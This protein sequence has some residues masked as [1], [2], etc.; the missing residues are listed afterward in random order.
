[1]GFGVDQVAITGQR[2]TSDADIFDAIDLPNVRSVLSLDSRAVRERIERLPWVATADL[3][4]IYPGQLTIRIAERRPYAVWTR[5]ERDYLVDITGRVLSP[6]KAQP[7][8]RLPRVAGQGAAEEASQLMT[9]L[10]R[11]PGISER[12]AWAERVGGRR[13]TLH[14]AGGSSLHLPA[15]REALALEGIL[16]SGRLQGLLASGGR[17]IDLRSPGRVAVRPAEV[18]TGSVPAARDRAQ[19]E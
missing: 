10:A 19:I 18:V 14:L 17:V 7:S 13:W 4:R 15:D 12:L 5:G 16:S 11:F 6:I 8:L 3:S 1:M 9:T 2:F